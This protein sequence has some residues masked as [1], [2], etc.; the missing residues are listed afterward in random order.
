[1]SLKLSSFP[2]QMQGVTMMKVAYSHTTEHFHCGQYLW[3]GKKQW[4]FA[5]S[6]LQLLHFGMGYSHL[7]NGFNEA[8]NETFR[9]L[10]T[11]KTKA[12]FEGSLC[13]E[14]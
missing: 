6:Y 1:M 7:L 5:R 12:E 8:C 4:S 14:Y 2:L 10:M 11:A 13:E 9:G 3:I